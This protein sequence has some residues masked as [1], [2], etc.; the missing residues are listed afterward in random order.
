MLLVTQGK[1]HINQLGYDKKTG[2]YVYLHEGKEIWREKGDD[3][4]LNYFNSIRATYSCIDEEVVNR[5]PVW[6][7]YVE[8]CEKFE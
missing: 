6:I 1:R 7:K 3:A 5:Y 2:E 8:S 4:L